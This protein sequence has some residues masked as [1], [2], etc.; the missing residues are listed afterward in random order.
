MTGLPNKAL[1]QT[2]GAEPRM[3][4]PPAAQRQRSADAKSWGTKRDE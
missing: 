1:E 3:E 4:A 2:V